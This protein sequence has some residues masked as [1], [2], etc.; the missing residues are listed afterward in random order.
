MFREKLGWYDIITS[1]PALWIANT[2]QIHAIGVPMLLF[3]GFQKQRKN[4][5]FD[6]LGKHSNYNGF[7]SQDKCIDQTRG[8]SNGSLL[9][10][11]LVK[12]I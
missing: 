4:K 9:H 11:G 8:G 5:V 12:S 10:M 1:E 7:F 6:G 3:P 2:K